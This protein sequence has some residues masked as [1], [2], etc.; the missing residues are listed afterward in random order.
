MDNADVKTIYDICVHFTKKRLSINFMNL[1]KKYE[2]Y[3]DKY[4]WSPAKIIQICT[5]LNDSKNFEKDFIS[6]ITNNYDNEVKLLD[7]NS[8][9]SD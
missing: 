7:I 3:K 2:T 8:S 1:L 4:V 5:E 6:Y 9:S